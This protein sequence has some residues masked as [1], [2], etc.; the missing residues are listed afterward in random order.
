MVKGNVITSNFP[1]ILRAEFKVFVEELVT[2]LGIVNM[3]SNRNRI[4]I[5]SGITSGKSGLVSLFFPLNFGFVSYIFYANLS[6]TSLNNSI[7]LHPKSYVVL[8]S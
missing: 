2:N 1:K 6:I 8:S 5:E 7:A 4:T 3:A